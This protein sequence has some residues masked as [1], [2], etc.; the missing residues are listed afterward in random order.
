MPALSKIMPGRAPVLANIPEPQLGQNARETFLPLLPM[1]LNSRMSP[2]TLNAASGTAI[3]A[4]WLPVV[5]RQ[6]MQ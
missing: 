6:S 5:L 4:E 1:Q 3:L 2:F